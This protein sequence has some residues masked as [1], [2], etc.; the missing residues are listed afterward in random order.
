MAKSSKK[1]KRSF[2]TRAALGVI[3][4]TVSVLLAVAL[5]AFLQDGQWRTD[6]S[7]LMRR[8]GRLNYLAASSAVGYLGVPGAWLLTLVMAGLSVRLFSGRRIPAPGRRVVTATAVG[9]LLLSAFVALPG[10]TV[11]EGRRLFAGWIGFALVRVLETLFGSIGAFVVLVGLALAFLAAVGIPVFAPLR[12][13]IPPLVRAFDWTRAR[14]ENGIA[15]VREAVRVGVET[16]RSEPPGPKVRERRAPEPRPEPRVRP[17]PAPAARPGPSSESVGGEGVRIVQP[18]QDR[19]DGREETDERADESAAI[20][21]AEG[22]GPTPV[23]EGVPVVVVPPHEAPRTRPAIDPA[24]AG[25]LS[26]LQAEVVEPYVR[27]PGNFLERD[28]DADEGKRGVLLESAKKLEQTLRD[29]GVRGKVTQVGPG[30]VITRYEIEPAAGQKVAP[31]ASLSDDLALALR[32]RSIRVVAPIPGKA[33]VGIEVPNPNPETVRLGSLLESKEF[34]AETSPLAVALGRTISGDPFTVA[35][36]RLPHLLVAGATGSGK[37]VCINSIITSIIYRV[38]PE[39]VRFIM[40]DPKML[41]LM[42]YGGLPHVVPPVVTQPK[43]IAKI[44]KWAV[45][46]MDAR[47]RALAHL[48]VRSIADYN[49]RLEADG[50]TKMPYLVVI[51]DELADLMLS[52]LKVDIEESIARLAQMARAVGIHLVV[53]T[54]R[55]SVDVITGVIKANFPSRIA[56]QVPTRTDS[57]TILD[58]IGAEK[59]LGRGDMLYL[60]AGMSEPVRVH[61][62]FLSTEETTDVVEWLRAR[63]PQRVATEEEPGPLDAGDDLFPRE[64]EDDLFE[65]ASRILVAH[66]QGSISLLQRRLKVG[67]ARA[68]RLVDMME[69]AGIVG[70]FT[71][72]KAREILIPTLD[73]LEKKLAA[74]RPTPMGGTTPG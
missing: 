46:E 62:S 43:E 25:P 39:D 57:R 21:A 13:T 36:D 20:P 17:A 66:Q 50:A 52:N 49:R 31:I 5:L 15:H 67:Y 2:R 54:Q 14:C 56:F 37:S 30:P 61:G 47:Y 12:R 65:E 4:G 7:S 58:S 11:G 35:L 60:G 45:S 55:P 40:I 59:L 72:S 48:G 10:A 27:P 73:E 19:V 3:L 32:A 29:F 69:E 8:M 6:P 26:D 16:A 71:G 70:P 24:L 63:N 22:A 33:A 51:V 64:R 18:G 38:G 44:L 23:P 1:R 9:V 68:A 53:A 74:N 28:D 34:L 42:T 41:E